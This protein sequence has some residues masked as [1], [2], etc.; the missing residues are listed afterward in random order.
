[1]SE[2]YVFLT[3]GTE[4]CEALTMV[5]LFRRAGISTET[6]ALHAD[7]AELRPGHERGIDSLHHVRISC[8]LYINDFQPDEKALFFIPGGKL[9]VENMKRC[10]KLKEVLSA[11][12]AAGQEFG[13]ICAGPTVLGQFGL[14]EGKKVTVFPGFQDQLGGALYEDLP[15]QRDTH[16]VTGRALGSAIPLALDIISRLRDLKTAEDTARQIVYDWQH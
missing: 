16:I 11:H 13:S 15:L 5:D 7:G 9:G 6:V 3:D 10:S 14:I 12:Q 2:V 4:E 8:D 1:M